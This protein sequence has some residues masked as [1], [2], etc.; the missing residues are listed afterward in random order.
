MFKLIRQAFVG[1]PMPTADFTGHTIIVTGTNTGLGKEAVKHFVRCGAERVVATVRSSI[2][3]KEAL[4]EIEAETKHRDVVEVWEL[5]YSDYTS[6]RAFCNKVSKLDRVDVVV[7]NAGIAMTTFEACEGGETQVVVNFISTTLLILLLLPI[8]RTSGLKSKPVSR[9]TVV[10]SE[11][12]AWASYPERDAP[13]SLDALN[14]PGTT[15]MHE[16]YVVFLDPSAD[17]V[18]PLISTAT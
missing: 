3:G 11:V 1:P 2:K 13:N 9:L 18:A 16:R 14:D 17:L 12:H 5:D 6:V 8:L 10:G 4:A 7:L 15:T